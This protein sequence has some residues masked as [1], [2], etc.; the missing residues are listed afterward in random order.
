MVFGLEFDL[1]G[2]SRHPD[3][4]PAVSRGRH[5]LGSTRRPAGLRQEASESARGIYTNSQIGSV[6]LVNN[7]VV[8]RRVINRDLLGGARGPDRLPECSGQG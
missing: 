1:L 4:L 7:W 5:T 3:R 6:A 2:G 8:S